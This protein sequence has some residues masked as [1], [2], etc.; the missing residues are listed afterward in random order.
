MVQ[1]NN[2]T[3]NGGQLDALILVVFVILFLITCSRIRDIHDQVDAIYNQTIINIEQ[4]TPSIG[5]D[6]EK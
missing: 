6:E 3:N 4:T 2:T 1:N 5:A